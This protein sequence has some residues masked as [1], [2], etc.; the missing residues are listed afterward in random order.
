M[1]DVTVF[2][3]DAVTGSLPG[4]TC[5]GTGRPAD[6]WLTLQARVG[7]H[8]PFG[9][10]WFIPL[11]VVGAVLWPLGLL[12][13]LAAM[14][15]RGIAGRETTPVQLPWKEDDYR[16]LAGH[17]RQVRRGYTM[18]GAGMVLTAFF[19]SIAGPSLDVGAIVV[20]AGFLLIMSGL[21]VAAYNLHQIH[22]A[23]VTACLDASRRWVT[24]MNVH[25]AFAVAVE[26]PGATRSPEQR[27]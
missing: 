14:C 26:T 22:K 9:A 27:R 6:G 18:V 20:V 15:W 12:L 16:A 13:L 19:A 4:E 23:E 25:P 17:E 3:D 21:A 10:A 2:V 8:Y 1:A 24:F 11:A 7:T 5:A